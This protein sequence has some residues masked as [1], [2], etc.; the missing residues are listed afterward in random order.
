MYHGR[1]L[2]TGRPSHACY[3]R[4]ML[5]SIVLASSVLAGC[6]EVLEKQ[7]SD[8]AESDGPLADAPVDTP[9]DGPDPCRPFDSPPNST[10]LH[11]RFCVSALG[12]NPTANPTTQNLSCPGVGTGPGTYGL[13]LRNAETQADGC[14]ATNPVTRILAPPI[15]MG[16]QNAL[17]QTSTGQ[18][19]TITVGTRLRMRLA[20]R[21]GVANCR[22][23]VQVTGAPGAGAGNLPVFPASGF[24]LVEGTTPIDVDVALPAGLVGTTTDLNLVVIYDGVGTP[25]V[26][27]ENPHLAPP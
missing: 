23:R 25:D 4:H 5:R 8:A 17:T 21:Q 20:C 19:L 12:F 15:N 10:S 22:G 13:I 27:F 14:A 6:G 7:P 11:D 3:D 1:S 24:Q 18:D 26:L 2:P 16:T 9:P